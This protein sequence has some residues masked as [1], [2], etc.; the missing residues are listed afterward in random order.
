MKI[1]KNNSKEDFLICHKYNPNGVYLGATV[2]VDAGSV[3]TAVIS[4]MKFDKKNKKIWAYL[5]YIKQNRPSKV[6]VA[7]CTISTASMR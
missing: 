7:D 2:D 4:E 5:N 1:E 6:D 3:F